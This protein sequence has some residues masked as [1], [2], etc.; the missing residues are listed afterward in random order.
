MEVSKVAMNRKPQLSFHVSISNRRDGTIEAMTVLCS[1]DRVVRSEE[2]VAGQLIVDYNSKGRV[3]AVEVLSSIKL[4]IILNYI[5][6]AAKQPFRKFMRTAP[7][8][9]IT[10]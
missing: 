2:V 6:D 5:D 9:L 7:K 10:A 8:E 4:N 3:V 1:D